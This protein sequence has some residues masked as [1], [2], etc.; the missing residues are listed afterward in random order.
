MFL[1]WHCNYPDQ[2]VY[3]QPTTSAETDGKEGHIKVLLL[4]FALK[5][6]FCNNKH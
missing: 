5:D 6:T 1:E 4:F 2:E 3:D